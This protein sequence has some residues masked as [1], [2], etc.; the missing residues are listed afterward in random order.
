VD[1]TNSA[2]FPLVASRKAA[3]MKSC[4][5]VALASVVVGAGA[6]AAAYVWTVS[7]CSAPPKQLAASQR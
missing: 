4:S 5:L 2:A 3:P 1:S 7:G 6:I